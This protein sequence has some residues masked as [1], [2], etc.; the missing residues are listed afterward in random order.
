MTHT[1]NP[2]VFFSPFPFLSLFAA[3]F[4]KRT[5]DM[6]SFYC[7]GCVKW[8]PG[9]RPFVGLKAAKKTKTKKKDEFLRKDVNSFFFF[10]CFSFCARK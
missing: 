3:C 1:K 7:E 10:V 6:S 9:G 2:F 5:L 8:Q 4:S